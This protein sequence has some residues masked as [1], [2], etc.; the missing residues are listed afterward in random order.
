M[1]IDAG[2]HG[3][4]AEP[5]ERLLAVNI[6]VALRTEYSSP[7]V[8][9]MSEDDIV[10]VA[11][12]ALRGKWFGVF[13]PPGHFPHGRS[14]LGLFRMALLAD[15][16]GG[17]TSAG[18]PGGAGVA[19]GAGAAQGRVLLVAELGLFLGK[20]KCGYGKEKATSSSE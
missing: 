19:F 1:A 17:P 9:G 18:L 3:E 12:D 11:V 15:F 2:L 10:F 16:D 8:S 13:G 14:Y 20:T 4:V 6:A 7:G 5:F